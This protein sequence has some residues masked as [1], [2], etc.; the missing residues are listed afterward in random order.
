V[1]GSV[2]VT[3]VVFVVVNLPFA[4][5]DLTGSPEF[6]LKYKIQDEKEVPVSIY[7]Y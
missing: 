2:A 6:L 3:V 1:P 4:L 7:C 5:L